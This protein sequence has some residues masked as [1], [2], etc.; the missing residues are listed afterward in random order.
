VPD[1]IRLLR[2]DERPVMRGTAAWALGR[3][4]GA[5]AENALKEAFSR[6]EDPE[7]KE[8]IRRALQSLCGGAPSCYDGNSLRE[9]G[10][11]EE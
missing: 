11:N 4:G 2:G 7:A 10:E 3:I 6:E 9:A 1:L 8:E 5:E